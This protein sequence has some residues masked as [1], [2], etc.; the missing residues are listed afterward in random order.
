[1]WGMTSSW[2]APCRRWPRRAR[3][4]PS[5][6]RRCCWAER[7]L[8]STMSSRPR[9]CQGWR[10]CCRTTSTTAKWPLLLQNDLYHCRMTSTTAEGPLSLQNGLYHCRMTSISIDDWRRVTHNCNFT[11]LYCFICKIIFQRRNGG[12]WTQEQ[13]VVLFHSCL[14]KVC[15]C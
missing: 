15:L 4:C 5:F 13:K 9:V 8:T 3:R 6:C 14:F 7:R 2:S 10:G 11:K 1:M 12:R